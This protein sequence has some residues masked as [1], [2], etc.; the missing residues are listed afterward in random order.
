MNVTF[1]TL[2]HDLLISLKI[3]NSLV[4]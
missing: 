4:Y 1:D 3:T 2:L